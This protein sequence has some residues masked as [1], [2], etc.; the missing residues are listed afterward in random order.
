MSRAS[1]PFHRTMA[2]IT[3]GAPIGELL[4][5]I[6]EAVE[7]EDPTIAC[8]VYLVDQTGRRLTLA[9]APSLPADYGRAVADV[10]IGPE[11]GSCGAAAFRNDRVIVEDIQT[12]PLWR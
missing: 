5:A 9:A 3:V 11:V 12:D 8:S 4:G 10:E 7:A 6:V 2:L 1:S